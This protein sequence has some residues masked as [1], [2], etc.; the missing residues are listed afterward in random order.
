[1]YQPRVGQADVGVVGMT[2]PPHQE[3]SKIILTSDYRHERAKQKVLTVSLRLC[4]TQQ[5]KS[6]TYKQGDRLA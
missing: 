2:D 5:V 6:G 1:M 4:Q 3:V